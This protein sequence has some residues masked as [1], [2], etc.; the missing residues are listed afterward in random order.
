MGVS[1]PLHEIEST[2]DTGK[3]VY[4]LSLDGHESLH[5]TY[6]YYAAKGQ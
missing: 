3:A 1:C 6:C 2:P 5:R 4:N